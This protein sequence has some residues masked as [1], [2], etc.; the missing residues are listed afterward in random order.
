MA[1]RPDLTHV[2]ISQETLREY[3]LTLADVASIIEQS[4][5]DVPAGSIDTSRGEILLRMKERKEWAREMSDIVLFSSDTGAPLRLGDIARVRDGF[6]E[7]G[8]HSQ[9]NRQPSIEVEIFRVGTQSP[10]EVAKSVQNVLGEL[11][12]TLPDGVSWRWT[13][14]RP[15]L[16][17]GSTCC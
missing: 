11:E 12:H 16:P 14:N 10:L 6:E 4:S 5:R 15:D 2:E 1:S 7:A 8:F 13:R 3:D 9:F 17:T